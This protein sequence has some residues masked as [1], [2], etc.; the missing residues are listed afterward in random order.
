[1][2]WLALAAL[3]VLLALPAWLNSYAITVFIF[4]FFY[5]FL[6]QAWN[7]VGGYAG[8]LSAGHAAFV[9]IGAYASAVLSAQAGLTPWLGMLVGGVLSA[10]LG[11]LVG[12]LGF[13]FGLRGFYFVLLTV[14]FAEVCRIVTLNTEAMGG[15]LEPGETPGGGLTM[16]QISANATVRSTK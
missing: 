16:R 15:A 1:V 7:I 4:I 5:A 6:G 14:A 3:L 12:Y 10:G 13:R 9:G 2:R 8:Q 11:T